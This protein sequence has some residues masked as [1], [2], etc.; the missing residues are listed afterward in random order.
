MPIG[1]LPWKVGCDSGMRIPHRI[2]GRP[3][4]KH[5]T[6]NGMK[7]FNIA[8]RQMTGYGCSAVSFSSL[9]IALR[10]RVG[11]LRKQKARH[12]GRACFRCAVKPRLNRTVALR[13]YFFG[14]AIP[15]APLAFPAVA[16]DPVGP[17]PLVTVSWPPALGLDSR[18]AG[19]PFWLSVI[20]LSGSVVFVCANVGTVIAT[21]IEAT[22]K[23]LI[24]IS[25]RY[26]PTT[27]KR[28][29]RSKM[30]SMQ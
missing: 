12:N 20:V 22:T 16:V 29:C 3:A 21:R 25:S 1:R 28:T 14:A 2:D 19:P 9:A 7:L 10:L 6:V 5:G 8:Q 26:R 17:A 23:L 18:E 30:R 27:H 4:M 13:R 15:P 24:G 11:L